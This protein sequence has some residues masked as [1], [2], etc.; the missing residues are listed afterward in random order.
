MA[1]SQEA[2][3]NLEQIMS[4]FPPIIETFEKQVRE[5]VDIVEAK[6][7]RNNNV[8]IYV[9]PGSAKYLKRD[10]KPVTGGV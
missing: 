10:S 7:S 5:G 9:E 2:P 8:I 4:G 6:V 3:L 1:N